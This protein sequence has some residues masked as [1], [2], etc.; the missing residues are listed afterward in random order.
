MEQNNSKFSL[1]SIIHSK[2]LL[3]I[4]SL[5][6]SLILWYMATSQNQ[7]PISRIYDNVRVEFLNED[8]LAERSLAIRS[9]SS[10]NTDVTLGGL[11]SDLRNIDAKNLM[12]QIDVGRVISPGKYSFVPSVSNLQD[13]ISVVSSDAVEVV[14]ERI[15]TKTVHLNVVTTGSVANGRHLMDEM[16]EYTEE[17]TVKAPK[18]VC[19]N[20]KQAIATVDVSGKQ[21]SYFISAAV[22]FVDASGNAVDTSLFTADSTD[23]TVYIPIFSE[24]EVMIDYESC[25]TGTPAN[26]YFVSGISVLPM[27]CKRPQ[28]VKVSNS[29]NSK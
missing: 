14:I 25:I 22:T 26:G 19:D 9:V 20:I 7:I 24:K 21:S 29:C 27:S 28:Q 18:S 8:L 5:V 10:G 16:I 23:I 17:V 12:A 3:I 2:L 11:Y 15:V 1:K 13:G 4:F 6:I